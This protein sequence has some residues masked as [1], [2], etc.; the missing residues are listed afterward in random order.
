MLFEY[1]LL[2]GGSY[3]VI[4]QRLKKA[5]AELSFFQAIGTNMQLSSTF[6][7]KFAVSY[8][9]KNYL[10]KNL[11]YNLRLM[12]QVLFLEVTRKGYYDL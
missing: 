12:V 10:L 5:W 1:L 7:K 4:R 2:I 9:L 8:T 3:Q 6:E 11:M